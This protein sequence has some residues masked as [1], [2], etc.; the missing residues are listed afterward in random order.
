MVD[1]NMPIATDKRLVNSCAGILQMQ[2]Q[3]CFGSLVDK[4]SC[5]ERCMDR[6]YHKRQIPFWKT[7]IHPPSFCWASTATGTAP[8]GSVY[9]LFEN[10]STYAA[11]ETNQ[12]HLILGQPC[13]Q[14]DWA[15]PLNLAISG[16]RDWH[17][18]QSAIKAALTFSG[19]WSKQ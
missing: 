4:I 15:I 17:S 3:W 19:F 8:L 2:S 5:P 6:I 10:A 7:N 11:N 9:S 16:L 12:K 1:C 14:Q 13:L 18:N